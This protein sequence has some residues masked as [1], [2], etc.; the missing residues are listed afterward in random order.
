M[1]YR[2]LKVSTINEHPAWHKHPLES[3]IERTVEAVIVAPEI[4]RSCV[5]SVDKK[6]F[7]T[8]T[9]TEVTTSLSGQIRFKTKNSE[10]LLTPVMPA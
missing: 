7:T 6:P 4:G 5:L 1:Q 10:Y 3:G 2:L 9:V 8:S